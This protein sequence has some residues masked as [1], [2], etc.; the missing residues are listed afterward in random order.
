MIRAIFLLALSLG[1]GCGLLSAQKQILPDF[2]ADPSARV[3]HGRLYVYPSHDLAGSKDWDM[4]DWH[5]FSTDDMVQWKDHGEIFSLKDISWADKHAWAPDCIERNG[6]YYFYFLADDQIG[7]AVSNSPT[8]P[9]KDALGKPLIGRMEA[10]IR[11]ID[12]NI[13]IDDDGQAYLYFGNSHDK[14]AVVKLKQD[15]ITRDDPIQVLELKNYHEGIWVHKRKGLYYFSY[16]SYRGDLTANLL[17]YSVAK[18]PTGPFEYKGVILDNRSRNV[19][20]SITEYK[21]KW[22]LFYHVAGPSA[23]ERRVCVAPLHYRKDGSIEPI[24]IAGSH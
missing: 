13:F 23:Y 21:G 2:Q 3:F 22:W 12:P 1:A 14:V 15:M 17:E 8:G 16:P 11:S 18:S 20:G 4:R 5:V 24:S 10:G 6:K 19:H 7:V 9:F